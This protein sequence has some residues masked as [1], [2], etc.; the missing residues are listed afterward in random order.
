MSQALYAVVSYVR[1]D[2]GK[3]I[4]EVRAQLA[5]AQSHLH[6]HLTLLPPRPLGGT[7]EQ[8]ARTLQQV[9]RRLK[10]VEV[11]F[12]EVRLF[13]PI[14]P[15]VYLSIEECADAIRAMHDALNTG[16]L[17][18]YEALPYIPHFTVAALQSDEE[19]ERTAAMVRR[20][21]AAYTGPRTAR[22]TELA[23]AV[24]RQAANRWEDLATFPLTG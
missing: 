10:P 18:C 1:G 12:G 9:C 16:E 13:V 23:F 19:A 22:L 5:P 15:T 3:F 8:A 2:L 21:W 4:D 20:L 7:E 14:T 24:D 6:A 11:S 17:F